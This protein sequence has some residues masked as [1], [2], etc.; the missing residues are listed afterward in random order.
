MKKSEELTKHTFLFFKG[1][2]ERLQSLHRDGTASSILRKLLRAY[3]DKVDPK[4]DPTKIK[5][6]VNV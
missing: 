4:I 3:L 5:G 6:D 2:V 1:D